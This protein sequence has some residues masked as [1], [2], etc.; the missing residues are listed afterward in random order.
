M[1][2]TFRTL[3]RS[4]QYLQKSA[5]PNKDGAETRKPPPAKRTSE[6]NSQGPDELFVDIL[7]TNDLGL[8]GREELEEERKE[9]RANCCSVPKEVGSDKWS[10]ARGY[11]CIE[12]FV[13][14]PIE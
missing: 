11:S 6:Y 1:G 7:C 9:S 3:I 12:T 14:A 4:R 2:H 5:S 10:Q 13:N 8:P